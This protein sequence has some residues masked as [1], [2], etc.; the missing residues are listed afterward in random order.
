MRET[1]RSEKPELEATHERPPSLLRTTPAPSVPRRTSP[2]GSVTIELTTSSFCV[3]RRHVAP[4]SSLIHS[5][6]TVPANSRFW[7]SGLCA[8]ARVR[9]LLDGMP[10]TLVQRPAPSVDR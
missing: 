7:L 1:N 5:P 9:R 10:R 3:A 2:P 6:S 4:P 8:K